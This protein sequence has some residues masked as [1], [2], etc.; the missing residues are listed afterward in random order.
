MGICPKWVGDGKAVEPRPGAVPE[1]FK[2]SFPVL[3]HKKG[4]VADML[5][6]W[7]RHSRYE[8]EATAGKPCPDS[9]VT[10]LRPKVLG[11]SATDF[12][13]DMCMR[14]TSQRFSAPRHACFNI[15]E[16]LSLYAWE[17]PSVITSKIPRGKSILPAPRER[18]PWTI[19][20][21]KNEDHDADFH[22]PPRRKANQY[23]EPQ[24]S[25]YSYMHK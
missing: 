20:Q 12:K 8:K 6:S 11:F 10:S 4:G 5:N 9:I 3:E 14:E 18:G 16:D 1:T 24:R 13:V 19:N 23:E 22:T 21:S 2:L 15:F 7:C 17:R 25:T